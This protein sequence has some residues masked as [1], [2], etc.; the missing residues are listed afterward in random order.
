MQKNSTIMEKVWLEATNDFQQRIPQPS[1]QGMQATE[2]AIFD[3]MNKQFYNEFIA[4]LVNRIGMVLCRTGQWPNPLRAFKGGKLNFGTTVQELIPHWIEAHT[5]K[6]DVETL[7]KNNRPAIEQAF[8]TMNRQ[9]KYPFTINRDELRQA[10]VDEYGLNNFIASLMTVPYNSDNY[11]EYKI[12]L[13]QLSIHEDTQGFYK[14][15][16]DNEPY[17]EKTGK[18]F[19]RAV[20]SYVGQLQFPKTIFN[21]RIAKGVPVFAK[22]EEL[23][24]LYTPETAANISVEVLASLFNVD[25]A[26]LE[27]KTVLVDEFPIPNAFALLTTKD[28]FVCHDTEYST[29]NFFNPETLNVN[30]YLHHWGVYSSSPFVPAILFTT[31]KGTEVETKKQI[32][33]DLTLNSEKT[34]AM[35][36]DLVSL[37]PHLIGTFGDSD[38]VEP[39][40]ACTYEMD[41]EQTEKSTKTYVDRHNVL[42]IQPNA[43]IGDTLH[44]KATSTY[45]NPSEQDEQRFTAEIVIYIGWSP[46]GDTELFSP[47]DNPSIQGKW[48]DSNGETRV[49]NLN[50]TKTGMKEFTDESGKKYKYPTYD[51]TNSDEMLADDFAEAHI[52]FSLTPGV[53][54]KSLQ[55]ILNEDTPVSLPLVYNVAGGGDFKLTMFSKDEPLVYGAEYNFKLNLKKPTAPRIE[56]MTLSHQDP[57]MSNESK[58][59]WQNYLHGIGTIIFDKAKFS[60][61][62]AE[63][64]AKYASSIVGVEQM[65]YCGEDLNNLT[66]YVEGSVDLTKIAQEGSKDKYYFMLVNVGEKDPT[67]HNYYAYQVSLVESKEYKKLLKEL[68]KKA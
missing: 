56:R 55:L 17:D 54:V 20:R 30:F 21:S 57:A 19:L 60:D 22:K 28:W 65:L 51:I 40:S 10:F 12:M 26:Q 39:R 43:K 27:V 34:V 5:Y 48:N 58:L 4:T 63:L 52:N 42:H 18:E 59:I 33:T 6:D 49:L 62:F 13:Q 3:P 67:Y 38:D 31:G 9:D 2:S 1:Q 35:P 36:G 44:I 61:I 66:P 7:L 47:A 46:S 41:Y 37:F 29:T 50:M 16:L 14:H 8:H 15:H 23:I 32:I 24:L 68:S 64:S 11:D 53:D 45:R 25:K